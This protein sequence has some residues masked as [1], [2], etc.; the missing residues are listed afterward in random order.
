MTP[1]QRFHSLPFHSFPLHPRR[2]SKTP[3][4]Y[5]GLGKD[6][7]C[8]LKRNIIKP[9]TVKILFSYCQLTPRKAITLMAN[10]DENWS[11]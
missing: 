9:A 8:Y 3:V 11:R 10:Q 5:L 1:T 4:H 2:T 7:K 6:L